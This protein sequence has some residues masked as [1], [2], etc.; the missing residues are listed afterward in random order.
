MLREILDE[1]LGWLSVDDLDPAHRS[2]IRD[3][4]ADDLAADA[5]ARLPLDLTVD[6]A[7]ALTHL[8]E[9]SRIASNRRDAAEGERPR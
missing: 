6:R 3:W 5:R 4:L 2:A 9:L 1:D 7:A 8:E